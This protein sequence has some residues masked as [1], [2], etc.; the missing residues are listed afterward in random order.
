M[1][2]KLSFQHFL[3]LKIIQNFIDCSFF[4][5]VFIVGSGHESRGAGKGENRGSRSVLVRDGEEGL[6]GAGRAG[7]QELRAQHARRRLPGRYRHPRHLSTEGRIRD[8]LWPRRTDAGARVVGQDDGREVAGHC[9]QQDGRPDG[10]VER[11]A[12]QRMPG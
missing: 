8:G 9:H 6:H 11:G 1:V 4:R 12:L 5:Q 2:D 3:T 7:P 10:A